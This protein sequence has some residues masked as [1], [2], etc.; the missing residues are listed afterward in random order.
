MSDTLTSG[1][2]PEIYDFTIIG[3]GPTGMYGA[4]YA[5]LRQMKT[6]IIDSLPQLGGQLSALYPEKYIYDVPGFARVL[7]STL[8]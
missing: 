6:K 3:G 8:R 1:T 7:A 2:E 5:G 4:F